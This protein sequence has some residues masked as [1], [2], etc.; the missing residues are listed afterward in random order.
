MAA[1]LLISAG[2]ALAVP[3]F[4][5]YRDLAIYTTSAPDKVN[6]DKI[7]AR[8]QFVNRGKHV[9]RLSARLKA[10]QTLG[11]KGAKYSARVQPG[12]TAEWTW[13][14]I[15]PAGFTREVLAGEIA[16]NGRP[17]RD[18]Y[19]TVLEADPPDIDERGI[20]KITE[21][22]RVVATFAPRQRE[23]VLAQ[24]AWMNA[25]PPK[26]VLTLAA[27]GKTE[28]AILTDALPAPPEGQ[29]ALDYW[30]A[31]AA[32]TVS[33][34][35][36]VNALDDLCRV[37]RLQTDAVLPIC[38]STD[39][40]AIVLRTADPGSVA[41]GLHDA[42]HLRTTGGNV[43]IEANAPDGLRNGVYGL[44]TDHLGCHWFMP[45]ELGEEIGIPAD[46]T[47]RL[48]ALDEVRGSK[49]YSS[50]GASWGV[51]PEWNLRN[52]AIIN[53]GRLTFG[54]AWFNYINANEF[55]YDKFPKYYAR[56]REGHIRFFG[57]S[58]T[59]FCSTEPEVIEIVARKVNDYFRANPDAIVASLDPNDTA[60]MCLCDR[61]LALDKQYGQMKDDGTEVA[62]RLLHF[63]KEIYDRLE[64]QF[65]D[66][67]LG[68]LIYGFQM[69]PPVSAKAHPHLVGLI[70][71]TYDRTRPWNDPSSTRNQ[72]FRRHIVA[73]GSQLSQFGY[74]EYLG[75][76]DIFGPWAIVHKIREDMPAFHELGGTFLFPEAQAF[77]ATQGMNHYI[78]NRLAWDLDADVDLLLEEFFT[79]YYGPAV[80]P[81][82][83]YWLTA[84]RLYALE[85]PAVWPD[86][87]VF[88][89]VDSLIELDG[90]LQQAARIV[91]ALPPS[92]QRF[93]D[94]VQFTRD[95]LEYWRLL[96]AY[97]Q[98]KPSV[99][100]TAALAFLR[101]HGSRMDEL[102]RKYNP[103]GA[104]WPPLAPSWLMAVHNVDALLASHR[105]ALKSAGE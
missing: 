10:A 48:P 14:F 33:Q 71:D 11:F 67:Y 26:P 90:Y 59:N 5:A 29:D 85:R 40:P 35:N 68:I 25:D 82:R 7:I 103:A 2:F 50:N 105:E 37:V 9:L 61:C 32:L 17:E 60:P 96:A 3:E 27:A 42:Y 45:G 92:Q 22:A 52:R 93:A 73:W 23:S 99:N 102:A 101:Q 39:G 79:S 87:Q 54:H 75:N 94:R 53:Q 80:E 4:P 58:Y 63:S 19:I 15:A 104:Y 78:A 57:A 16:L 31:F 77:F 83:N 64:P 1:L 30:R 46:R 24:I 47:A 89:R 84:E 86:R 8:T 20:E 13:M 51:P 95:G 88:A 12:Q 6:P 43:V 49:W 65:K 56:D 97:Q 91:A 38:A 34:R 18:L 55:P 21:R 81:M 62:D 98:C 74:Y 72:E 28:Y 76:V 44:L 36:L 66:R 69:A 70:C 41:E 100:H